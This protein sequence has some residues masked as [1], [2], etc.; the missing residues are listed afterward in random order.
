MASEAEWQQKM[1]V[2]LLTVAVQ[3]AVKAC[4]PDPVYNRSALVY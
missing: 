4:Q 2:R 3:K 1:D